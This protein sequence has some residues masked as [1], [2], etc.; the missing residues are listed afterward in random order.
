MLYKLSNLT[1]SLIKMSHKKTIKCLDTDKNPE[2][3]SKC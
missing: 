3:K 1:S 2:I